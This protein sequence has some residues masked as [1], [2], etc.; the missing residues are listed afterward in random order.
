MDCFYAA[1]EM[2]DD[3]RLKNV[4]LAVGGKATSRGVVTTANYLARKFGV[5][6]AMPSSQAQRLCR[7]LVFVRPNFEKY[8]LESQKIREIFSRYTELIEP[9]SLDEA[10]LDV[11]ASSQFSGSATLIAADI[12]KAIFNETGLTASA[13][14]APNKFLAKVASDWKKPNGQFTIKPAEIES[15]VKS[16]KLSKIPGVGQVT[17]KKMQNMGFESCEDL[18]KLSQLQLTQLFGKWG[19]R[20]YDLVRGLDD[21]PVRVSRVRKSLSVERTFNEDLTDVEDFDLKFKEIYKEFIL[22]LEKFKTK[23]PKTKIL[24]YS[25]KLKFSDF[26]QVTRDKAGTQTPTLQEALD[27]S[28]PIF[29]G[30]GR[31]IR[32]LGFGVKLNEDA[33]N[34][35]ME[36]EII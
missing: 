21:R 1:V 24:G 14:I 15:F 7:D 9:L 13:G 11:T 32:L 28:S 31:P 16:L 5:K 25:L 27:F 2:R 8:R 33:N 36:F 29:V 19:F 23:N 22:R 18:Q 35:Q 17:F 34:S 10:Y 20:L 6:S 26:K 3:P 30:F 4:P 12:R